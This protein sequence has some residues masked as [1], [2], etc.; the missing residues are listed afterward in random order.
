MPKLRFLQSHGYGG[1]I[2]RRGATIE[3]TDIAAVRL[4]AGGVAIPAELTQELK[5]ETDQKTVTEQ[6]QRRGRKRR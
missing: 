3:V 6:P 1:E 5:T 4:I 2:I